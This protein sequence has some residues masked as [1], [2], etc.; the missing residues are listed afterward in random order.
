MRQTLALEAKLERD[1]LRDERKA[2]STPPSPHEVETARRKHQIRTVVGRLIWDE[3]EPEH[4]DD[5]IEALDERIEEE[6]GRDTFALIRVE[7]HIAN[8]R[9]IRRRRSGRG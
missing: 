8:L 4:I 1:R 2:R 7:K 6:A 5:L 3:A 9:R